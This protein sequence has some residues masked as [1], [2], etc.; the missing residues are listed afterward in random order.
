MADDETIATLAPWARDATQ[1]LSH[2][3]PGRLTA[4]MRTTMGLLVLAFAEARR[5]V[6]SGSGLAAEAS[7]G[8]G[9]RCLARLR[10]LDL[11]DDLRELDDDLVHTTLRELF[12]HRLAFARLDI[13]TIGLVYAGLLDHELSPTGQLVRKQGARKSSGTFY[14]PP[15]LARP[16]ARRCLQPLTHTP[17]QQGRE[18][19]WQPKPPEQILALRV[20]DPAM[21][22]G[23]LLLAA[24]E[25]LG[26]ALRE[27]MAA[28][29]R[30]P[31]D[32][33]ALRQQVVTHCLVGV[34]LDPL[35]VELARASLWLATGAA[36]P[37]PA[38]LAPHLRCGNALVGT[39]PERVRDYPIQA[40][41]RDGGDK[42][43]HAFVHHARTLD[44]ADEPRRAGDKWTWAIKQRKAELEPLLAATPPTPISQ[45]R[46]HHDT[47]CAI[48]FWPADFLARA[49]TPLD[50]HT[51]SEPTRQIVQRLRD[52]LRFFHWPLEFCE[53][54]TRAEPGFDAVLANPPWDIQKPS[55]REFFSRR[56]PAYPSFGKQ[57]ALRWQA[58]AFA[59]EPALETAW[60][61]YRARFSAMS[62]WV[63]H[64][65]RHQGAADLNLYKLFVEQA[66]ALTRAGGRIGLIVPSALHTD[67]G[68]A[69]LREL[70]LDHC[71]WDWLFGFDNRNK[72]FDIDG[73]FEFAVVIASKG[74]RTHALRSAF[75][76]REL[77]DWQAEPPCSFVY[78]RACIARF[79]PRSQ[80]IVELAG[81]RELELLSALHERGVRL[82]DA[83]EHGWRIDYTREFDLT[84]DSGLFVRSSTRAQQGYRA[85]EYGH[86]L[87]GNWRAYAG[88]R[89]ILQREPN[90]VLSADR[91]H[92]IAVGEIEAVALPLYQ[93]AM[94]Q[95][96]DSNAA[97]PTY[98]IDPA[99]VHARDKCV[100]DL[101]FV[102]RD[103]ARTTDTRTMI[104]TLL[105]GRP[106]GNTLAVLTP[107]TNVIPLASVLGSLVVDWAARQRLGGTHLNLYVLEDIAVPRPDAAVHGESFVLSLACT[108]DSF[109][110]TWLTHGRRELGWR[111]RWAVTPHERLRVRVIL[112]ALAAHAF[113][114]SPD[115]LATMLA[116]C[117]LPKPDA[118][119]HTLDAKGLW[120][121]DKHQ[122]PE[123]RHTV[124]TQV[125]YQDL[126]SLGIDAFLTQHD[127]E[128]WML[129]EQLRL[130]DYGLGRDDRAKQCQ[131]VAARL[132][133]RWLDWQLDEDPA[134]C[135]DTC[136]RHASLIDAITSLARS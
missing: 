65:F 136:Q 113:G 61:D 18:L 8:A 26:A 64:A 91:R 51:P 86:W 105:P 114:L 108:G 23:A 72:V 39:S 99:H 79:S 117:D 20:C 109:A 21:G 49:P 76:R 58:Q 3:E 88:P 56:E 50:L 77:S 70:L 102:L 80:A 84:N 116:D 131:A 97:A 98:L 124:L 90:L 54:F 67:K 71:R 93:G 53:V 100:D 112:D 118:A 94:I 68:T 85:D 40:W 29:G 133:P 110:P 47:W 24:L 25:H 36:E 60:I 78:P 35:A 31:I 74:G 92:A 46:E 52:E 34:D 89:E 134:A 66:H 73:R 9:P 42:Q 83:S 96:F 128:G 41:Q 132:G 10:A 38:R 30:P 111:R 28:H 1:R 115:E 6:A 101:K 44:D 121:V 5:Q 125:A 57:Q 11:A 69:P 81:A 129:P 32:D 87:A 2:G 4:A 17:T 127:G 27:S 107:R 45:S 33:A 126:A 22:S 130:A 103:I 119:R 122:P 82:G 37:S 13:E 16:T 14:T 75:M 48:W 95:P 15:Q 12:D 123:L 19:A 7:A 106:C 135:W 59:A 43:H 63:R 120:R 62:N 104:G 55:S